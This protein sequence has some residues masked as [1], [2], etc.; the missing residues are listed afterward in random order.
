[1]PLKLTW[2][3]ALFK[4]IPIVRGLKNENLRCKNLND[5]LV[6]A[7]LN[8]SLKCVY[9]HV[10]NEGKRGHRTWN[11]LR[12]IGVIPGMSDYLFLASDKSLC[13]EMKDGKKGRQSENQK[14]VQAWCESQNV[15]Y[16]LC[17]SADEA[18]NILRLEGY[19]V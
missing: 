12:A 6:D 13:I 11:I 19:L 10:P 18:I 2:K 7:V 4:S 1:M 5:V 14:H 8:D 15:P 9:C 3:E 16:H 17:R